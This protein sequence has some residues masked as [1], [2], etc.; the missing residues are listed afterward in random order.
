M[1]KIVGIIAEYNPFHTGH[2]RQIQIAREEAGADCVIAVMSET[3]VQ[4]GEP[5]VFDKYIRTRM[6]LLGGADIVLGIPAPFSCAAAGD[7]AL[8]G[9]SLLDAL[10]A[11]VLCFGSESG[12]LESLSFVA[13]VL[14]K[15]PPAYRESLKQAMKA[16]KT[17]PEARAAAIRSCLSLPSAQASDGAQ[18]FSSREEEK[19]QML[20][21]SPNN[22]LGIEYLL[23]L[24]KLGSSVTPFTHL[25]EGSGY[26]SAKVPG[27]GAFASATALRHSL[28]SG[29]TAEILSFLP[30][31][32]SEV[33][34]DEP[35]LAADDLSGLLDF[36]LLRGDLSPEDT[37]GFDTALSD[38]LR[39]MEPGALSFTARAEYL[40]TRNYTETRVRRALIHL[41]LNIR[42]EDMARWK[43]H[44]PGY[45]RI[46]GFRKASSPFLSE[47][48]KRAAVPLVTKTADAKSLLSPDAL[49]LFEK[50]T[51]AAHIYQTLRSRRGPAFKNEYRQGPVILL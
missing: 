17:F 38:R 45:A 44:L 46:L 23:A 26:H 8:F 16:G 40:K 1:H 36:L 14:A 49:S 39:G 4:R 31:G 11:D 2:A 32:A 37:E 47:I 6:A 41:L 34:K 42:K 20:L 43:S 7:F 21:S 28:R 48:R 22:I 51:A 19:L 15:E 35:A 12:N 27:E 9:V 33:I 30:D 50:E 13:D 5:A 3:F 10:G 24:R 29:I 18:P 25:R